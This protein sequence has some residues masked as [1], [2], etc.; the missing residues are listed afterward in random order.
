MSDNRTYAD[1]NATARLRPQAREA[2]ILAM[3]ELGGNPSSVHTEG[4]LAR[5]TLERARGQ[6]ANLVGRT[7]GEIVFTSGATEANNWV[8]CAPWRSVISSAVEHP[9]ILEAGRAYCGDKF[10]VVGVD[11]S[12]VVDLE[13]LDRVLASLAPDSELGDVLVSIQAA[14]GESGVIQPLSEIADMVWQCG[15]VLHVDAAQHK[16]DLY[17]IFG[18]CRPDLISLSAHKLGGPAGVGAL[19]IGDRQDIRPL[20]YGGG[21]EVRRRAGTENVIGIAGFGAAAE[22]AQSDAADETIRVRMLRDGFER[23]LSQEM[24][25]TVILGGDA[26]R[27]VNT[28]LFAMPGIKAETLVMA[29]DL[30]GVAI[31]AGSACSSGKV[32]ESHVVM[33]MRD[34]REL[35]Q[36]AAR[37]SF[38]WA[39]LPQDVDRLIGALVDVTAKFHKRLAMKK[40]IA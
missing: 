38:G 7:S 28:S 9:S 35:A 13:S 33:A 16:G 34:D 6:V 21:Q 26:N 23:N 27:M 1:F 5:A 3:D 22:A 2:M 30:K 24:P 18:D 8:I 12:G 40:A 29:L 17:A 39:S 14:N 31:S 25:E 4:R 36:T 19:V 10:N 20:I 15:G 37:V 11:R 32:S